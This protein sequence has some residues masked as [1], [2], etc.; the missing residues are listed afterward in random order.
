MKL[1]KLIPVGKNDWALVDEEDY[2]EL[3]KRT[4]HLDARNY[5]V[6]NAL[7][8]DGIRRTSFLMHRMVLQPLPGFVTDHRNC[9]TL[10]NRRSN[11]RS[12]TQKENVVNRGKGRNVSYSSRFKGVYYRKDRDRWSAYIGMA[13]TREWLGC[14]ATEEEAGRAYNEAAKARWGEFAQ[15]ND[16][17]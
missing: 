11:L 16:C 9:N 2:E 15:L 1:P 17:G 6:T 14:Y 3:I 12:A 7:K 4:W 10:D 13:P 8:S 5:A